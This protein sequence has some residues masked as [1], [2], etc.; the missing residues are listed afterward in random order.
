MSEL[1]IDSNSK[2]W[3]A[4]RWVSASFVFRRLTSAFA[5]VFIATNCSL[6]S[7]W[8]ANSRN[9]PA[10]ILCEEIPEL[11]AAKQRSSS[12]QIKYN[13]ESFNLFPLNVKSLLNKLHVSCLISLMWQIC[14]MNTDETVQI[15]LPMVSNYTSFIFFRVWYDVRQCCRCLIHQSGIRWMQQ[16]RQCL[17]STHMNKWI[18]A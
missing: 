13:L 2:V 6:I 5:G 11:L 10:I 9:I 4:K 3:S 15:N 17:H 8:N 1:S 18:L 7:G 16:C 12:L 14:K